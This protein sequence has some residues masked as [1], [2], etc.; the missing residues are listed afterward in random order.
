ME[1]KKCRERKIRQKGKTKDAEYEM[2]DEESK[3]V[4]DA[5]SDVSM[6]E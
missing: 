6:D 3:N 5:D 1:W 4:E 2:F